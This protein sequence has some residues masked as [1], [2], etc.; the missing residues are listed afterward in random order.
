[1]YCLVQSDLRFLQKKANNKE[2][3]LQTFVVVDKTQKPDY[4][5]Y[6]EKEDIHHGVNVPKIHEKYFPIHPYPFYNL[7]Q[8]SSNPKQ[9]QLFHR[10]QGA[11]KLRAC[12]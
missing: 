3:F 4:V 12:L 2:I 5:G 9:Q 11:A 8:I 6:C 1:M 7:Q 10:I